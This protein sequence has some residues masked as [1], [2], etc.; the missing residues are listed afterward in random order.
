VLPAGAVGR[1]QAFG[2]RPRARPGR[3]GRVPGDQAHPHQPRPRGDTVV[4]RRGTGV[5]TPDAVTAEAPHGDAG[6]AKLACTQLW[7]VFGPRPE[8]IVGSPDAGLPRDELMAR[9]GCVAAV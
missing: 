4:R 6:A 5:S 9:T 7:K 2:D 1:V 3:A 8:R